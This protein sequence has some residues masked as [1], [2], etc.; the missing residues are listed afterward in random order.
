MATLV[1]YALTSL[2]N[3]KEALDIKVNADDD[4]LKNIINRSTDVV[5]NYCGGRRFASTTHTNEEY[6]GNGRYYINLKHYPVTALTTYQR[7]YG[8]VGDTDWNSLEGDYIK[9]VSDTT[10]GPGQVYYIGGF[11]KGVRNYRFTYTA[12]YSTI[13]NDLEEACIILATYMYNAR[14]STGL[15]S[16]TLGEYSY[17]KETGI[18]DMIKDLGLDL[19]LDQYREPTI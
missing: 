3:L 5:E 19:I 17:T 14:K 8:T 11:L 12:G 2:A 9:L 1:S 4:L 10:D 7:N 6:D 13:P 15:K 16:E 18:K